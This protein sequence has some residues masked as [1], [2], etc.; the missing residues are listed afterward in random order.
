MICAVRY[1]LGWR[2]PFS[3]VPTFLLSD[4]DLSAFTRQRACTPELSRKWS[5]TTTSYLPFTLQFFYRS[6]SELRRPS[7]SALGES[8][9][10]FLRPGLF[11]TLLSPF[12]EA[13]ARGTF[14][15]LLCPYPAR[16]PRPLLSQHYAV[17]FEPAHLQ[18][19][20]RLGCCDSLP[21][22]PAPRY[23]FRIRPSKWQTGPHGG[24]NGFPKSYMSP[25]ILLGSSL[26]LFFRSL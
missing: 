5:L 24:S 1:T 12:L 18:L 21:L 8:L 11:P 15:T 10:A 22:T 9:P 20:N 25:Q 16:V 6:S 7:A 13:T 3:F 2:S 26:S 17:L 23:F 4:R 14:W 19:G